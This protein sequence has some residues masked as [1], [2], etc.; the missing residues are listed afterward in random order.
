MY[1]YVCERT[2]K[3]TVSPPQHRPRH[4]RVHRRGSTGEAHPRPAPHPMGVT[5]HYDTHENLINKKIRTIMLFATKGP[6]HHQKEQN[7][8]GLP[9]K[10]ERTKRRPPNELT[11]TFF[12]F[13][14]MPRFSPSS[15]P[16]L[17]SS[18]AGKSALLLVG[19]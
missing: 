7:K 2:A 9:R 16:F 3:R 15:P 11:L 18:T 12:S 19:G 13:R 17:V 4:V 14:R 6:R 1:L 8:P 5:V 10:T